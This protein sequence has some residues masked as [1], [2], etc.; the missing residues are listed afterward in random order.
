MPPPTFTRTLPSAVESSWN[1]VISPGAS[2]KKLAASCTARP[3][4]FMKVIGFSSTTRSRS[5]VPSAVS[6]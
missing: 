3:D 6:P 2:L 1:T 4:S 5:S